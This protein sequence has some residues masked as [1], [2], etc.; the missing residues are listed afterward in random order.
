VY[1][2]ILFETAPSTISTQSLIVKSV[3]VA[4]DKYQKTGNNFMH[5]ISKNLLRSL[6][7]QAKRGSSVA[8]ENISKL[9]YVGLGLPKDSLNAMLWFNIAGYD[10]LEFRDQRITKKTLLSALKE[11]INKSC[12][13]SG[14]YIPSTDYLRFMVNIAKD[15]NE[16]SYDIY[17]VYKNCQHDTQLVSVFLAYLKK[18]KERTFSKCVDFTFQGNSL[19]PK[20]LPQ[21][22]FGSS[23]KL[24]VL[25]GKLKLKDAVG[26]QK[27]LIDQWINLD[28]DRLDEIAREK[29][30]INSPYLHWMKK[31]REKNGLAQLYLAEFSKLAKPNAKALEKAESARQLVEAFE[32]KRLAHR[33]LRRNARAEAKANDPSTK[34]FVKIDQ[35]FCAAKDGT[36]IIYP[37]V[38]KTRVMKKLKSLGF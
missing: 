3:P 17:A 23:D 34:F 10:A 19:F 25:K 37:N 35:M 11:H 5:R 28:L 16:K 31:Y 30:D 12:E 8:C 32:R 4:G 26:D 21:H 20:V 9:Y 2:G 29:T 18:G 33:E 6:Y 13:V 1:S 27:N 38:D 24:Y 14:M 36:E 22:C 7:D 15:I